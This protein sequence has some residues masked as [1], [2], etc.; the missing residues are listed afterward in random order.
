[1]HFQMHWLQLM[2][3]H[4]QHCYIKTIDCIDVMHPASEWHRCIRRIQKTSEESIASPHYQHRSHQSKHA[5]I[6]RMVSWLRSFVMWR[7]FAITSRAGAKHHLLCL[8]HPCIRELR[9][10][11]RERWQAANQLGDELTRRI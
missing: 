8:P 6:I 11:H 1:M 2:R 9:H 5:M 4:Q 3:M 10:R 7:R